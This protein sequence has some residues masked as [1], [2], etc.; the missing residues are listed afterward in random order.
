MAHGDAVVYGDGVEFFGNTARRFDFTRHQLPH[1]VQM[2]M[3][4]HELGEG[5]GNGDNGLA[6]VAV[7][8]AG[9]APQGAGTRHIAAVGGGFGAVLRHGGVSFG[10]RWVLIGLPDIFH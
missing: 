6:E 3:A 5:V 10:W 7:G 1:I 8:H 2:H 9:G 4:G